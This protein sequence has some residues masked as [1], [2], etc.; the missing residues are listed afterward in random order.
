EGLGLEVPQAD[1]D[2]GDGLEGDALAA[3]APDAPEHVAPEL[4][5]V[6][7]V[8]ADEQVLEV[9]LD[10]GPDGVQ[11]GPDAEPLGAFVGLDVDP[12]S[13]GA[14]GAGPGRRDGGVLDDEPFRVPQHGGGDVGDSHGGGPFASV[15]RPGGRGGVAGTTAAPLMLPRM[16]RGGV[17]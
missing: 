9:L 1:V 7:G 6:E 2:G 3:V 12:E 5:D 15:V 16:G 17:V 8:L 10:D 13:L 11:T 4:L 14:A